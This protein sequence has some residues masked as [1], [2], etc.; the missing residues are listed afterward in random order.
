MIG[1]ENEI[2]YFDVI[3]WLVVWMDDEDQ[4][5]EQILDVS[6]HIRDDGLL[7]ILI[8]DAYQTLY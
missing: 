3:L 2:L 1:D 5:Y 7:V 4:V 6:D 8:V